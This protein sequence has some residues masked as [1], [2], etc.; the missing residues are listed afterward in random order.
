MAGDDAAFEVLFDRHVA[1][2]LWFARE[3]L[4]TWK[5][6]EE[7][8]R[9]SFAAA[10]AYLAARG[11]DVEFGPW[12]RTILGNHCLSIAQAR[13]GGPRAAPG[14]SEVTHLDEW[15]Q[16]RRDRRIAL[17]PFAPT[18]VVPWLGGTAAKVAVVAALAGGV[19][20]TGQVASELE[21]PPAR[22]TSAAQV[23][24]GVVERAA[25]PLAGPGA[26]TAEG[27]AHNQLATTVRKL[28]HD[29]KP[30]AAQPGA[31]P[32]DDGAAGAGPPTG[33]PPL[34]SSAAPASPPVQL[35][36]ATVRVGDSAAAIP[37]VDGG[38]LG[39]SGAEPID[40]SAIGDDL[41][42]DTAQLPVD[43]D[44]LLTQVGGVLQ[45]R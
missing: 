33:P 8:V 26:P 39:L 13:V 1:D 41:G 37:A 6:A 10:K 18:A 3:A 27:L 42:V 12:L 21:A 40:L 29:P 9:H 20:V 25:Q 15:R 4:G 36:S 28:A 24:Q 45:Q 32:L 38:T 31:E 17:L 44:S 30:A 34:P 14:P 7:A 23:E 43:V 16:R 2:A 11:D 35:D 5:E 19:G 22:G